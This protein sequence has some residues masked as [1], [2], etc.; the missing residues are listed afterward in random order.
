MSELLTLSNL[1]NGIH[2]I[3]KQC[4]LINHNMTSLFYRYRQ[5]VLHNIIRPGDGPQDVQSRLPRVLRV[6]VQ[7]V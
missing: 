2:D 5:L 3:T 4:E 1:N 7:P 6:A